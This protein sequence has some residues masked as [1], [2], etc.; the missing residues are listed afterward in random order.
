MNNFQA[1]AI[2]RE[3]VYAYCCS[4]GMVMPVDNDLDERIATW[5]ALKQIGPPNSQSKIF[6]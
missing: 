4:L 2:S 1:D 6:I 5:R 3:D